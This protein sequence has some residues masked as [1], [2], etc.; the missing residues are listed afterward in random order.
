MRIFRT[1]KHKILKNSSKPITKSE[2]YSIIIALKLMND[3][4]TELL[5]HPSKERYYIHSK[6]ANMFMIL[7]KYPQSIT[8][9]NHKYSY[10]IPM[11]DRSI[12]IILDR[13]LRVT[14]L[15]RDS[16]EKDFLKNT[17]DSLG[18]ICHSLI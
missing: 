15:R 5:L 13:F 7:N 14:E 9:I 17:E 1:I 10:D 6:S 18:K 11:T 12:G 8:I 4:E 3:P 2:R 16:L